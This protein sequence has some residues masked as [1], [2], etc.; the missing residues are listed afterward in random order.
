MQQF[1]RR[2]KV[3]DVTGVV[4]DDQQ[5][6]GTAVNGLATVVHFI[7]RRRG[8][9]LPWASTIQHSLAHEAAVHRLMAA[10]TARQDRHFAWDRPRRAGHKYRILMHLQLRVSSSHAE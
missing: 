1:G 7:R 10:T 4:L 2:F 3:E 5:H 9:N 6:P 8:E